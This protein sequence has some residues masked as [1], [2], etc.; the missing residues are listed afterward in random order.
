MSFNRLQLEILPLRLHL[1]QGQ[2]NF[3]VNFF[4]NDTGNDPDLSGLLPHD[5]D[6]LDASA[7]ES[8]STSGSQ[9]IVEEALLPFFQVIVSYLFSMLLYNF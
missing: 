9:A 5:S 2:L 7:R 6:Q 4:R 3:L 8:T 1:D